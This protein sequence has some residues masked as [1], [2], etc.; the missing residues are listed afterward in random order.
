MT[1]NRQRVPSS[2]LRQGGFLVVDKQSA[3]TSR[4]VV[5]RIVRSVG[6]A[7][8][9]HSG[10]LDPLASGILI[11]CIG[12]ATRLVEAFQRMAKSYETA[13]D[14]G[15]CSD[16]LDADGCIESVACT[17]IPT[18]LEVARVLSLL[19]GSVLQ[20]PPDFSALKIKGKRAYELARAGQRVDLTPRLVQIDAIAIKSYEWPRLKLQIDCASGTYIRSIARDIG[21]LLGCGGYVETLIRT[22][23]GPFTL[24][25]AVRLDALSDPAAIAHFLRPAIEALPDLPRVVLSQS[26]VEAVG[27][28]RRLW[29][30]DLGSQLETA[31]DVALTSEDGQFVALAQFNPSEGWVQ[32]RKVFL[33]PGR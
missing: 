6:D 1:R 21:E 15:A 29:A 3:M 8:V 10:T 30:T 28:G 5:N 20:R 24:K 12:A 22:K 23:V 13:I 14:L 18:E 7:K 19:S 2:D 32:P 31:G 17:S 4:A 27:C 16:T 9:G 11:I 26:Q 25:E 33:V